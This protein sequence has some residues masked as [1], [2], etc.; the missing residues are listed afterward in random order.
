MKC[1][2]SP[3]GK[4]K[5]LHQVISGINERLFCIDKIAAHSLKKS[6]QFMALYNSVEYLAFRWRPKSISLYKILKSQM[7]PHTFRLDILVSE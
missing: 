7:L 2:M 5:P 1:G 4:S 3:T 6:Q